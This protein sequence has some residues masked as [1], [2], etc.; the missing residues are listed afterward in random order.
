MEEVK[1]EEIKV[2][3]QFSALWGLALV[4]WVWAAKLVFYHLPTRVFY[5]SLSCVRK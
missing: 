2:R 5:F 1:N 4:L 3:L